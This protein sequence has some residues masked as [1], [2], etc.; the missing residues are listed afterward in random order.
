[1]VILLISFFSAKEHF[2]VYK[3]HCAKL[4]IPMHHHAISNDDSSLSRQNTLDG[5]ITRQSR[6]PP[7]SS[8]GLLDYMLKVVVCIDGVCVE[9]ELPSGLPSSRKPGLPES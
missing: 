7:F 5:T 4:G 1:V 6:V 9:T 3:K 8:S 2:P